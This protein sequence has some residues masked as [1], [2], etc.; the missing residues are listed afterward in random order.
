MKVETN[1]ESVRVRLNKKCRKYAL[2]VITLSEKHLIRQR[3]PL[4][5]S[6]ENKI[7]QEISIE[8]NYLNW[9]WN[10]K[11]QKHSTQLIKILNIIS[12]LILNKVKISVQSENSASWEKSVQ[13]VTK[14]D[15]TKEEN[16]ENIVKRHFMQIKQL[17]EQKISIFYTDESITI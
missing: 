16:R 13:E 12:T 11:S 5:F 15:I 10:F 4:S 6:S 2:K 14:I 3:T 8:L 1:L 9:N 17:I 7:E